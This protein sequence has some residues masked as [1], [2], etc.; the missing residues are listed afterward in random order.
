M[1]LR[2]HRQNLVVWGSPGGLAGGYGPPK[3]AR[4]TWT[5]RIRR[6]V[7]TGALLAVIGLTHLARSVRT[8]RGARHLVAGAVL[9]AAGIVLPSG[10]LQICGMLVLLRG[11][12]VALGVS[13]RHRRPGGEPAA[14][15][16]VAGFRTPPSLAAFQKAAS[17]TT[18]GMPS[19]PYDRPHRP[20]R[21]V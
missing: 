10:V 17:S 4:R 19:Q 5:R 14:G 15:V 12:A 6:W 16:D 7:R 13:E 20:L 18:S 3:L 1:R 2:S 11:V 21:T 9:T 8:R